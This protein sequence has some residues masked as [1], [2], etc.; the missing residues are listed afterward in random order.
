MHNLC[1]GLCTPEDRKILQV[2][3][4]QT[5]VDEQ[6]VTDMLRRIFYL[7]AW[8]EEEELHT[9]LYDV[10]LHKEDVEQAFGIFQENIVYSVDE[11]SCIV[12]LPSK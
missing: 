5:T 2:K 7:S 4:N 12:S 1:L 8:M 3:I 11:G 10:K 9:F 6:V